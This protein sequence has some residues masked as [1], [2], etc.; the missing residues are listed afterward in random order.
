MILLRTE[1]LKIYRRP[2]TYIAFAIVAGLT[3]IIQLALL[4]DGQSFVDFVMQGLE[5]QFS[6]SGKILNGYLVTYIILQTLL[7]NVP[8]LVSI[9]AADQISGEAAGGTLRLL[10]TK[11]ISRT[12]LLLTKYV[13]SIIY[14]TSLLIWLAIV[15]LGVSVLLFGTGDMI[16]LRSEEVV[17]LLE[18]DLLWRYGA[19]FVFAA[20]AMACIASL[21]ILLSVFAENSI[22]PIIA[23]MGIVLFFTVI[24]TLGLPFFEQIKPWLFTTHIIGWKGFFSDP[25]PYGAILR[26]GGILL[27]YT[28]LFLLS[29]IYFFRKKDIQS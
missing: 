13:A 19:A 6:F 5:E 26:S 28:V 9:I 20:L 17:F 16:N 22:G 25:V 23:T 14:T 4:V 2:R 11:P 24:S 8:Q 15:G 10:L 27:G 3:G 18:D 12:R 1:L 21:S 7:V 29:A